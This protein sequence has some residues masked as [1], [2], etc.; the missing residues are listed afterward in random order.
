MAR[1][2][3]KPKDFESVAD[4]LLT[5]AEAL[6]N[7][8]KAMRESGMPHALVHG[9]AIKNVHLPTVLEWI[10]K[11]NLDVT[12]QIDSYSESVQSS[13]ELMKQKAESQKKSAAKKPFTPKPVKKKST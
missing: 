10:K 11:A 5:G 3:Q 13:A 4:K 12:L 1:N 8:A 2:T 9:V 7:I 6:R